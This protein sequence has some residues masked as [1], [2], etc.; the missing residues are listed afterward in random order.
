MPLLSVRYIHWLCFKLNVSAYLH[1]G[2][3]F[4]ADVQDSYTEP[5]IPFKIFDDSL[6]Q[7]LPPGDT[8]IAYPYNGEPIGSV[9]LEMQRAGIEDFELLSSLSRSR[10][11]ELTGK[12]ITDDFTAD[13]SP[14][15]FDEVYNELLDC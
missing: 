7:Y 10:A 8:N 5:S 15:L 2:F 6:E 14:E 4:Q 13:F 9:R 1:W 11:E 12:C 3:C